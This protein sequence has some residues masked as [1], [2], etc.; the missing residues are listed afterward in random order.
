MQWAWVV[1]AQGWRAVAGQAGRQDVVWLVGLAGPVFARCQEQRLAVGQGQCLENISP[2]D[3][4]EL[5]VGG[6]G[7]A[8]YL[9]GDVDRAGVQRMEVFKGGKPR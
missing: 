5:P 2:C 9:G 1:Q 6:Y 4:L 7:L 8:T 3:L